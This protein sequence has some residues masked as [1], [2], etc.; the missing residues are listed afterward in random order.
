MF[1]SSFVSSAASGVE[2]SCTV[3]SAARYTSA[4]AV[5]LSG[6]IPP[7]TFGVV[8]VVQSSRPGSTRSGDIAR[9]KSTS[10]LQPRALLEDRLEDLACR[11]GPGGRL[12]H[13]DLTALQDRCE[14]LRGAL[15]VREV[16]LPLARRGR[17]Q[18]DQ[19]GVRLL[20]LLVVRARDDEP[21]VDE[22]LRRSD[23]TSSMWL[24]PPFSAST[25]RGC[26]S[27]TSTRRPASA[28]VTASGRPT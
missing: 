24:V 25:M 6:V 27:M 8:F 15:D 21:L 19:D 10:G 4:A 14:A 11:A 23:V 1:S 5:V 7:T 28:N 20:H 17:R 9:W 2:T 22:R 12:E 13:D 18:R 26:T 16:G 3:S